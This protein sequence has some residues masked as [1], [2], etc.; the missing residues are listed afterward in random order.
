MLLRITLAGSRHFGVKT[1]EMLLAQ[2]VEIAGVIVADGEDRLAATGRAA[3]LHVHVQ[4]PPK[5][6]ETS[7]IPPGTALIITA[8][9]HAEVTAGALAASRLGGI[10]YRPSMKT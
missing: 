2:G 9:S 1:L 6:I 4:A 7:E 8:H 10:G 3:G 5:E